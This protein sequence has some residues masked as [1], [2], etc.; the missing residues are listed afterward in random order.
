MGNKERFR[1][2]DFHVMLFDEELKIL[3]E[4]AQSFGMNKTE[5]IRDMIIRG[6]ISED[7]KA[8]LMSDVKYKEL[9]YEINRIGNNL[10]Q[11]AY[12]SNLKKSTGKEEIAGLKKLYE[13][14]FECLKEQLLKQE[15]VSSSGNNEKS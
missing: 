13:E 11:I 4:K 2:R 7:R 15:S 5:Y 9:L 3:E 8:T 12:N 14:L 10:N 6:E 1:K